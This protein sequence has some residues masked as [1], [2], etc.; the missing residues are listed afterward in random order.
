M[1]RSFA[2]IEDKQRRPDRVETL[3]DARSQLAADSRPIPAHLANASI[4]QRER[5]LRHFQKLNRRTRSLPLNRHFSNQQQRNRTRFLPM[6]Q[7]RTVPPSARARR[8]FDGNSKF[9]RVR[10]R[11]VGRQKL[12][13]DLTKG[14]SSAFG[15]Y[16]L[17]VRCRR[18]SGLVADFRSAI[19]STRPKEDR[20][21]C[22][23]RVDQRKSNLF[24]A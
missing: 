21:L 18:S 14:R 15:D 8:G 9:L 17:P 12:L 7:C 22:R 13:V 10:R 11:I 16:F 6:Q 5:K 24:R 23:K 3:R 4:A 19:I 20:R 1:R 2:S